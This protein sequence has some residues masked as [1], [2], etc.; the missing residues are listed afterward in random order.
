MAMKSRVWKILAVLAI[1][2][3]LVLWYL[4]VHQKD[5][6]LALARSDVVMDTAGQRA[7]SGSFVNTNDQILRD[8]AVTVAFLDSQDRPVGNVSAE[9]VEL[10]FASRLD[11]QARLPADAVRLRIQSVRWRMGDT[12][13]QMG[14]FREPWEFGYLMVDR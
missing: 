10:P 1:L 7:W 9:A 4:V 12:T 13:A 5:E 14:P 6:I 8:V 2:P 3:V 11:L